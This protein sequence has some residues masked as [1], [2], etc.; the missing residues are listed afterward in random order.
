VAARARHEQGTSCSRQSASSPRSV[1][2]RPRYLAYEG[3]AAQRHAVRRRQHY[4]RPAD[5][6][7]FITTPRGG[8]PRGGARRRPDRAVIVRDG[9]VIARAGIPRGR[10]GS[11]A[12]AEVIAIR[13]PPARSAAGGSRMRTLR[14]GRAVRDV[15]RRPSSRESRSSSSARRRE[16]RASGPT[17]SCST[18][19]G[20]TTTA[21][22]FLSLLRDEV[23]RY[24]PTSS[25]R[26]EKA[27][28]GGLDGHMSGATPISHS[29]RTAHGSRSLPH[30]PWCV[31]LIQNYLAEIRNWSLF[32]LIPVLHARAR[33]RA[34][35]RKAAEAMG[36][37]WVRSCSSA[38][39]VLPARSAFGQLC[40]SS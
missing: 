8:A 37:F 16:G 27:R 29:S 2:S 26:S 19:P 23:E 6:D 3:A 12:H 35:V 7:R 5:D 17:R 33:Y 34:S 39:R 21:L 18:R 25:R 11:T 4:C 9:A 30:R 32:I 31:F 10:R 1:T 20:R 40:R 14:D 38:H 24:S 22:A 36:R 28:R 13:E 15:R